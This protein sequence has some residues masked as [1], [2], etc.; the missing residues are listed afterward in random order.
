MAFQIINDLE[1]F[2]TNRNQ[3]CEWKGALDNA[4]S[5]L[6]KCQFNEGKLPDWFNEHMVAWNEEQDKQLAANEMNDEETRDQLI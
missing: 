1:I 6:P 3:G 2:C 5:H 4:A